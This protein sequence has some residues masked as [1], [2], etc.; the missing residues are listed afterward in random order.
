MSAEN[1]TASLEEFRKKA[2]ELITEAKLEDKWMDLWGVSMR[3]LNSEAPLTKPQTVILLKFLRAREFDIQ[4]AGDMLTGTLKWRA[5]F[6]TI[7]LMNETFGKEFDAFGRIYGKDKNGSPVT[8]NFYSGAAQ[9]DIVGQMDKFLRWRVQLMEKAIS[10]LDFENGIETVT[11]VHDYSQTSFFMG[12]K[13]KAVTK[14]VIDIFQN[15]Y[16]EFLSAK[17]FLGVPT[18]M[19]YLFS[20]MSAFVSART[21]SKFKMVRRGKGR[22]A[23]L[24]QIE[25]DQLPPEYNGFEEITE[26]VEAVAISSS[27]DKRR[28]SA[29]DIKR[30]T[31]KA[32]G[33]EIVQLPVKE[34]DLVNWEYTTLSLDIGVKVWI[35]PAGDEGTKEPEKDSLISSSKDEGGKGNFTVDRKDGGVFTLKL[36]NSYSMLTEKTVL[37]RVRVKQA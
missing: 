24:E 8:Y 37:Y 21:R 25:P 30:V 35:A 23:L 10:L 31:I 33:S 4:K 11:Q 36:D 34:G 17:F 1:E 2:A 27:A 16:P 15:H 20:V 26:G 3:N 28:S 7:S 13:M 6:D 18:I 22:A 5:E 12:N 19:E 9:D 29:A 14:Q 32:G